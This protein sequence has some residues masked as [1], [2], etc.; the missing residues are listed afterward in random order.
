MN[1]IYDILVNL[2]DVAYDFFDW[3]TSDNIEHVR[4]IPLFKVKSLML[5]EIKKDDIIFEH[6]FMDKIKDCT[7]I[8]SKDGI[9]YAQ[10]ACLF[11]DGMEVVVIEFN[12]QGKIIGRSR[13]LI[14]E[15]LEVLEVVNR[16]NESKINY[17]IIKQNFINNFKTRQE[18]E[19]MNYIN[20]ELKQIKNSNLEKIRYLYYECFNEKEDNPEVIMNKM[21]VELKKNWNTIYPKI[22]NFFKLTSPNR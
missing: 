1:Y 4:K 12:P 8:F 14:D 3:N 17:K 9:E 22:Y 15:E 7:E 10:F 5:K 6:P 16:I 19:M 18:I 20:D 13:L 11:S 2:N 21:K